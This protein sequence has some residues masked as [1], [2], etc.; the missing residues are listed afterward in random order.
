[1]AETGTLEDDLG[2]A[3]AADSA[4]YLEAVEALAPQ[5]LAAADQIERERA[6]PDALVQSLAAAGLFR[7]TVPHAFGGL[8][9]D[10]L[11]L[12]RIVEE[13][14]RLDGSVGWC[15][16]VAASGAW[17]SGFLPEAGNREIFGGRP[18][19]IV[20]GTIAPTGRAVAVAGGFRASGRWAFA[21]GC[22][23]STWL[24]GN[25]V[26]MDGDAPRLM[27]DGV[28]ESRVLIF[29]AADWTIVDTWDVTGLRGTGSHDFAVSDAF[30][31]EERSFSLLDIFTCPS[32]ARPLYRALVPTFVM[33]GAHALGIA[34]SA[35]DEFVELART[36]VVFGSA[37]PVRERPTVQEKVARAEALVESARAYLYAT[38]AE[39]WQTEVRGEALSFAQRARMT[40]AITQAV[41]SGVQA[42]DLM[43]TAGG[44]TAVY[45]RSPLERR[46][47]DIHTAAAH[48]VVSPRNYE[49]TGRVLLGLEPRVPFY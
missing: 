9:V 34:R 1:M 25:C 32:H 29:S 15:V 31:P 22:R 13:L 18:G 4:S 8:E 3:A 40:L 16:M 5:I 23:H 2:T 21:S 30:V 43:Y 46:F 26:L 24:W 28:P 49:N 12:G 41:E 39:L 42:V 35:L 47:R 27:P 45:A 37:E 19:A 36:K 7:L 11:T 33:W 10:P 48:Q 17:A 6:L 14:A 44:G 20:G 38:A